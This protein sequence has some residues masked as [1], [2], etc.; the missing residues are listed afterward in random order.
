[1]KAD[2]EIS[3]VDSHEQKM[4]GRLLAGQFEEHHIQVR[5]DDLEKAIA[6][7]IDD[8]NLGFFLV[9]KK[10]HK[11]IGV[12]YV[13]YNWTLEHGGKSA[14]LEELYVIPEWRN[15]GV[16]Q[17]LLSAVIRR[18]RACGCAAID[19]EVDQSHAQAENLYRRAG[20]SPLSRA[21]WVKRLS[22]KQ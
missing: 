3:T 9:A 17:S 8:E 19:L 14:W 4:L 11:I 5:S 21:R 1:M 10:G 2:I 18:A 15:R 22:G 7:V 6:A 16:G 12:A 20:F 13:S